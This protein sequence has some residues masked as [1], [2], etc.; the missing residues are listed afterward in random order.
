M[1]REDYVRICSDCTN[2]G[3]DPKNGVI[4][5][6]TKE[7]AAFQGECKNYNFNVVAKIRDEERQAMLETNSESKSGG[8]DIVIGGLWLVA[9]LIGTLADT[10]FIF[11]GAIVFGG[12]Q[13]IKGLT[14]S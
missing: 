8:R 1:T 7:K 2:K 12:A 10:G 14:N 13:L 4:C 11:W 3:F 5:S 9:G 6:L